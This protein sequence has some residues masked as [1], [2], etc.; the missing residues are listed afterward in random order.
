MPGA[1]G[2]RDAAGQSAMVGA[3]GAGPPICHR[4]RAR[5]PSGAPGGRIHAVVAF[6]FEADV[7]AEAR[8]SPG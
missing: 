3:A 2:E 5:R 7:R 8:G 6:K 4:A 1:S